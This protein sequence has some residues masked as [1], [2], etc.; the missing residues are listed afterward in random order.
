MK[1]W[2]TKQYQDATSRFDEVMDD[3][4]PETKLYSKNAKSFLDHISK[5]TNY[6]EAFNVINWN[7]HIHR[8]STLIDMACGIGW[9]SAKLSKL[10]NVKKIYCIDSSKFYI[11]EMLPKIFKQMNGNIKKVIAVEGIFTPILLKDDTVDYII[12][13]AAIHHAENM[14]DVLK[15]AFRVLKKDGKLFI[16]NEDPLPS[17]RYLLKC[18]KFFL[19][20]LLNLIFKKFKQSRQTLGYSN[21]LDDPD[22]GDRAYP[23]WMLYKILKSCGFK[24][25]TKINSGLKHSKIDKKNLRN[26]ML[27]HFICKK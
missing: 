20:V 22:L 3:L 19:K 21:Y 8:N 15:E 16:L 25:V 5:E 11:K 17:L 12:L 14:Q 26:T 4:Y 6:I 24:K 7:I 18:T 9:V 23:E 10:K 1:S 13:S 27:I 2:L